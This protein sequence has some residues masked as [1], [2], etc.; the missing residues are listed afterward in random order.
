[1]K[2]KEP[3]RKLLQMKR[4]EDKLQNQLQLKRRKV[5]TK[6][7]KKMMRRKRKKISPSFHRKKTQIF[8]FQMNLG[9]PFKKKQ[10]DHLCLVPQNLQDWISQNRRNNSITQE[11]ADRYKIFQKRHLICPKLFVFMG[12]RFALKRELLK[13]D[14]Q[15]LN[16]VDS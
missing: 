7:I 15:Q 8:S 3:K 13:E 10:E 2:F 6:K 14:L 9:K 5:A 12:L 11:Y 4:R 1:M 16:I